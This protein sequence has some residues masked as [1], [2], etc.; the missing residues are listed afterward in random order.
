MEFLIV[1]MNG[2]LPEWLSATAAVISALG[3]F[4]VWKQLQLVKVI[5]Q[6]QF[7][8]AFEK[9]YRLL[10]GG[11]PPAALLGGDLSDEKY[12]ETLD[13]FIRY[14]DLSNTQA[15]LWKSGRVSLVTWE[16]WLTG[17]RFNLS[18]PA[19][20]RAWEEVKM[21]TSERDSEFFSELRQLETVDFSLAWPHPAK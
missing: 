5:A 17:I 2:K 7:E 4:F 15:C 8:D 1:A 20:A 16:N 14:F 19:F 11:I 9:E 21:R 13:D 12:Q 18:L 10:L 3:L 6:L